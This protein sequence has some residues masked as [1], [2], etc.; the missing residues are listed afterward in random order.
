M[1]QFICDYCAKEFKAKQGL[2]RHIENSCRA[3]FVEKVKKI[4]CPG[5]LKNFS[6]YYNCKVHM[7]KCKLLKDKEQLLIISEN[8]EENISKKNDEPKKIEIIQKQKNI[9]T[10]NQSI[11]QGGIINNIQGNEN[12]IVN[13]QIKNLEININFEKKGVNFCD[14]LS[15]YMDLKKE[16]IIHIA[17][18]QYPI[19]KSIEKIHLNKDLPQCQ[20][21]K[22]VDRRNNVYK[23]YEN[24]QWV[25]Y[26]GQNVM[27][28]LL[29]QHRL[30][31]EHVENEI[32]NI[33][34]EEKKKE[35]SILSSFLN[36]VENNDKSVLKL[37]NNKETIIDKGEIEFLEKKEDLNILLNNKELILKNGSFLVKE[38]DILDFEK[39]KNE[40][41]GLVDD[42]I[43]TK[44]AKKKLQ[45]CINEIKQ[46]LSNPN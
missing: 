12:K 7:E 34:Q 43:E 40:M 3:I 14:E 44:V 11:I 23:I 20:N 13:T 15:E 28:K 42:F 17:K 22:M 4:D 18:D 2:D 19:I 32:T 21:I 25:R 35:D 38:S 45:Y 8:K 39:K 41:S 16:D 10:N 31:L 6:T 24:G 1:N 26:V 36:L 33:H 37:K 5:C 9:L 27:E 30:Y 46:K 29:R